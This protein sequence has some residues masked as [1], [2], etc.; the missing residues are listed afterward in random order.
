LTDRPISSRTR[1]VIGAPTTVSSAAAFAGKRVF[2]TGHTGFKG[3]WLCEWL[4]GLGADVTGYSLPPPTKPSLFEQLGLSRRLKHIL[5]DVR[6]QKRL[7]TAMMAAR[8]HY[9]FHLA[10]QPIVLA[11]YAGPVDTWAT[12]VMGTLNLLEGLRSLKDPCATVIVTTDKVYGRQ[13]RTHREGHGLSAH[14][15]YGAS[16]AAVELAVQAWRESFG[17]AKLATARAGNVIG[18]GDWASD[19]L[20]P[21]CMRALS[22]GRPIVLR[23]PLAVRP[24]QHVLDPLHGYLMLA[25]HLQCSKGP[26]G[27]DRDAHGDLA[28]NFGP[29]AGD[30]RSVKEIVSAILKLWPGTWVKAPGATTAVETQILR[31]DAGKARRVLGWRPRWHFEEAVSKS[32]EWYRGATTPIAALEITRS[33]IA[34]FSANLP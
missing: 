30:H 33:Q 29:S 11:A 32:V 19:R 6:D 10:A 4:L 24:W 1:G 9:V 18:G 25:V 21:D 22:K 16:K 23:H 8:P 20:F 14:E 3:S 34:A 2:V 12:N 27:I 13:P 28:F 5:G 7:I 31:L 15:P 26:K 17:I